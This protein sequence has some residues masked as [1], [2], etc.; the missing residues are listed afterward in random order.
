MGSI[1]DSVAA[2][3]RAA[4]SHT[5]DGIAR[6]QAEA[7]RVDS[8]RATERTEVTPAVP[9]H[10]STT[11]VLSPAQKFFLSLPNALLNYLALVAVR[12]EGYLSTYHCCR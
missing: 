8:R 11:L 3:P 9:L 4:G 6:R 7:D 2:R 10:V 1:S 12:R 5:V